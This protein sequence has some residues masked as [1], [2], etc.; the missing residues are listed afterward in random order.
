MKRLLTIIGF[1][2]W[3]GLLYASNPDGRDA[4]EALAQIDN[5][6]AQYHQKGDTEKESEAR[7]QKIQTL[8]NFSMT[9]KQAEEASD[10]D[11]MVPKQPPVG[12]LLP[13][14]ATQIKCP[15]CNGKAAAGTS[16]DTT[17]AK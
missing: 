11:G 6:I 16:G 4:E 14:L 7:W 8:K 1:L 15:E 17:H 9:E 10:P 2:T 3:W 13:Y 5:Q 12:Q